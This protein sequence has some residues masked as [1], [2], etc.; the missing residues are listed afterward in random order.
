[1][2]DTTVELPADEEVK[3]LAHDVVREENEHAV[4]ML[5]DFYEYLGQFDEKDHVTY[6]DLKL[7]EP[8][9][10]LPGTVWRSFLQALV[11]QGVVNKHQDGTTTYTLN[12][13]TND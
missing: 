4:P 2:A 3:Q 9:S 13:E 12:T 11:D 1:M 8:E 6:E 7:E 5:R 10:Q